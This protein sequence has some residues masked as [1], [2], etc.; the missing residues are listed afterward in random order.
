M[1]TI[2]INAL[3]AR[4]VR[5]QNAL[6]NKV[7]GEWQCGQSDH[8][9]EDVDALLSGITKAIELLK[10]DSQPYKT[11]C[12]NDYAQAE[13]EVRIALDEVKENISIWS[14]NGICAIAQYTNDMVNQEEYNNSL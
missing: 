4:H 12:P 1:R 9:A 5:I 6:D 7:Y 10:N 3:E 8:D 14:D 13:Y 2:A 11:A